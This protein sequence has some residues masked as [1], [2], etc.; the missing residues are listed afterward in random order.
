MIE[1]S[2]ASLFLKITPLALSDSVNPCAFAVLLLVLISILTHNP[3]KREKILLGGLAFVSAVFIE[4]LFYGTVLT[5]FFK[6]FIGLLREN[7]IYFYDAIAIISMIIGG[8][9]IK[10]FFYYKRGE[11]A[12]EMPL[13]FWPKV[14]R[15]INKI[16]SPI[17]AF[18]VGFIVTL[19]LLPCTIGP[20]V[21]ASGLL[22]QL[23]FFNAL[24]W[25][26]YYDLIFILP[27]L[28]ITLIVYIGL[29]RIDNISE[30]RDKNIKILHL[31]AGILMLIVGL[32]ILIGWL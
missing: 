25:L 29:A 14:K 32:A 22:A 21:I 8:L 3:E 12:T 16:D 26:L 28:I 27:M 7:S 31:M 19:F 6:T 24:P 17:G 11:F 23:G 4:Y 15:A 18:V 5:Q 13:S 10:E 30:W 2:I 9:N 1:T 20:Y